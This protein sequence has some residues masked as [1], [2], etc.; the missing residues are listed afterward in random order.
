MA[1][2]TVYRPAPTLQVTRPEPERL[3]LKTGN[4]AVE[5]NGASADLFETRVLP[6]LDGA[7]SA[8][9]I[10]KVVGLADAGALDELLEGLRHAGVLL[11]GRDQNT[12]A[13]QFLDYAEMLGLDRDL[14]AT[15]LKEL[16]VAVIGDGALGRAMAAQLKALE[17]GRADLVST[18]HGRDT[19]VDL[20]EDALIEVAR[21]V[22]YLISTV[23]DTFPAIDHRVNRAVH[24]T[25]TAAFFAHVGLTKS[26][27]GPMVFPSETACFTC[28]RMRAAACADDFEQHMTFEENAAACE[29][30]TRTPASAIDFLAQTVC[31]TAVT[32]LLKSA[33]AVGEVSAVDAILEN[34]PFKAGWTRHIL[35]RR[36]DCPDCSK[37]KFSFQISLDWPD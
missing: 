6:L 3:L 25:R 17:L 37:K 32:E 27:V 34:E 1:V 22:D 26:V 13:S 7:H 10:A 15:R 36:P 18:G 12:A 29:H 21:D 5:L 31:G 14:I 23:G 11:H 28:W 24:E 4:T 2:E 16:R 9:D 35:L 8:S 33:L 19:P 20:S 30:P